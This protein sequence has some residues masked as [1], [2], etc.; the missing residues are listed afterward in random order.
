MQFKYLGRMMEEID[1]EWTLVHRN[2]NKA[3][4]VWRRLGKMLI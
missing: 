4:V 1:S 3:Q 2:I